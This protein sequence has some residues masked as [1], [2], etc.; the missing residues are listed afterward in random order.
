MEQ[1]LVRRS[2]EGDTQA[3]A[4]LLRLVDDDMRG[5]VFHITGSQA[6]TDDV[7]QDAYLKAFRSLPRFRHDASFG[8]WMHRIVHNTCI[9]W[10]RAMQR[11]PVPTAEPDFDRGALQATGGRD[12]GEMVVLRQ[13]LQQALTEL[14]AEQYAVVALIEGEG[15]SY[16]DVADLLDID[17]GTVASRLNRAKKA[18]RHSLTRTDMTGDDR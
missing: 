16:R 5:L 18:L 10:H 15:R 13:D 4:A 8:T 9:D 3:F 7:L 6:A 17:M 12:H 11:I 1:D 14:S 2:Q